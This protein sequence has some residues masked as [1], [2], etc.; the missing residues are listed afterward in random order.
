M[1]NFDSYFLLN[2]KDKYNHPCIIPLSAIK[3]EIKPQIEDQT[4]EEISEIQVN[5]EEEGSIKTKLSV[6]KDSIVRVDYNIYLLG[7]YQV[8]ILLNGKRLEKSPFLL[9]C[10]QIGLN[11]QSDFDNNG[12]F[13]FIS[14]KERKQDWKNP[15]EERLIS[16]TPSSSKF[17]KIN[18]IFDRKNIEFYTEDVKGSNIVISIEGS[19]FKLCP[20]AYS[21]KHG[22][23]FGSFMLKNWN[24][25]GSNDGTTWK[26]IKEH[27]DDSSLASKGYA[28]S[29]W[30]LECSEPFLYFRVITTGLNHNGSNHLMLGGIEF[31][32]TLTRFKKVSMSL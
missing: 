9:K 19:G 27:K 28:T 2:I 8:N 21:I 17:G 29:T 20:N 15:L 3:V 4:I 12:F 22:Y 16:V 11:Y 10:E 24:L 14:T 6:V 18:G 1:S 13:Y 23:N 5:E 25:E 30:Q 32:G 7:D 31:Y 26:V